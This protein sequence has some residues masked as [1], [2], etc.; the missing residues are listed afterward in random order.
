[1]KVRL[2]IVG[3]IMWMMMSFS[4]AQNHAPS[5]EAI[6]KTKMETQQKSSL[7]L[8]EHEQCHSSDDNDNEHS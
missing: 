2:L 4:F 5:S 6:S 8:A 1:M 3:A 7:M